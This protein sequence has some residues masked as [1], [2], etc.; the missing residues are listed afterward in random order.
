L[1][2]GVSLNRS[3]QIHLALFS[4]DAFGRRIDR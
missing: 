3:F 1:P 4:L 2:R